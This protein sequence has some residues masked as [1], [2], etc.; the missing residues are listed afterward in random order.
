MLSLS[1][2]LLIET[3]RQNVNAANATITRLET[4]LLRVQN[5]LERQEAV[6]RNQMAQMAAD[7]ASIAGYRAY[8]EFIRSTCDEDILVKA[9]EA[10]N[11]ANNAKADELNAPH[12]KKRSITKQAA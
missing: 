7:A 2:S 12:L 6:N 1:E 9:V 10:Y 8:V 5:E 11:E 3:N 4:E